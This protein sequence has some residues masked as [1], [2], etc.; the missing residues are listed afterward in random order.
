MNRIYRIFAT[1][2]LFH[3]A[4]AVADCYIDDNGQ[5]GDGKPRVIN[6]SAPPTLNIPADGSSLTVLD[7]TTA[8]LNKNIRPVCIP[9]ENSGFLLNPALGSQ[10][11]KGSVFT[12][13]NTG[14]DLR[15]RIEGFSAFFSTLDPLPAFIIQL[16]NMKQDGP[17]RLFLIKNRTIEPGATIPAGL[18]GTW[19]T[20]SGYV[21]AYFN[22]L[23][24]ISVV[25]ASCTVNDVNVAMGN[26]YQLHQLENV[27]DTTPPVAFKIPVVGCDKSIN[28][29]QIRL[30][31]TTPI[32]DKDTGTVE[33]DQHSTARGI[34]LKITNRLAGNI[35]M[36]KTY[37]LGS[38]TSG[39]ETAEANFFA[40]Y[41]RIPDAEFRAGTANTSINF[42][43]SYL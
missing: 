12:L 2:L 19:V 21:I 8:G 6:F 16:N 4:G 41:T 39:A 1:L 33:L 22:L 20:T 30:S 18:L 38:F 17:Y 29:I 3:S 13:R 15:L 28:K 7:V 36:D 42:V 32:V 37:N 35:L 23:N 43:M 14:L 25:A 24:P 27:G 5:A 11:A 34:G 26:D 10:P 31:A 40:A 9:E